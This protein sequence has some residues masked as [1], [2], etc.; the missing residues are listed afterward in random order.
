MDKAVAFP[1]FVTFWWTRVRDPTS[2]Y[3]AGIVFL[4][5][6]RARLTRAVFRG[7]ICCAGA[8]A[9]FRTARHSSSRPLR[10]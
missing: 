9:A 7:R 4:L 10:T 6:T 8:L 5:R 1:Y 2:S 3:H